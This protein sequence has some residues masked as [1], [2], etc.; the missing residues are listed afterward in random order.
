[1]LLAADFE[2]RG[3]W[4]CGV[5]HSLWEVDGSGERNYEERIPYLSI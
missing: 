4:P 1:M 5:R 3:D 2:V